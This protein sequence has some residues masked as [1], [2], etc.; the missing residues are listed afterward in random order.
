[1]NGDKIRIHLSRDC[2]RRLLGSIDY[3]SARSREEREEMERVAE[4]LEW[5]D[6][7]RDGSGRLEL[8]RET[9]DWILSELDWRYCSDC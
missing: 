9:L 2:V 6:G 4:D 5:E 7:R 8:R 1:M 3:G